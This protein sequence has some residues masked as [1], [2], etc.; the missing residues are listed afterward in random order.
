MYPLA[1]HQAVNNCEK[2]T[3]NINVEHIVPNASAT[4]SRYSAK[5]DTLLTS[6]EDL[7]K[8]LRSRQIEYRS[9]VTH[10]NI[11]MEYYRVGWSEDESREYPYTRQV[12]RATAVK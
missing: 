3:V 12:C 5:T 9:R 6:V 1:Q 7:A 10:R 2:I 4:F 8:V 11:E